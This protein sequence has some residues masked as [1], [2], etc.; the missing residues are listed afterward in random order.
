MNMTNVDLSQ[1]PDLFYKGDRILLHISS[2]NRDIS[3]EMLENKIRFVEVIPDFYYILASGYLMQCLNA[4]LYDH[5]IKNRGFIPN[6]WK[7]YKKIRFLGSLF[8]CDGTVHFRC[9]TW[10]D[11]Q[12]DSGCSGNDDVVLFQ[13]G[14]PAFLRKQ[15]RIQIPLWCD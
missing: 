5:L 15:E 11:E 4:T 12:W 7:G 6:S 8:R 10:D 3:K 1:N 14:Y 9:L 2:G 13:E